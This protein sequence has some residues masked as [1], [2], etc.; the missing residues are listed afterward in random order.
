MPL[1]RITRQIPGS[2]RLYRDTI[3]QDYH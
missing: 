2:S 3:Y 1:N